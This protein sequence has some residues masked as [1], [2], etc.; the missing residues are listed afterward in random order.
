MKGL[1]GHILS[2][3]TNHFDLPAA[4]IA[5]LYKQRW[6]VELLFKWIKHHLRIKS[7]FGTTANAVR[8]QLWIA[9]T[10]YVLVAILKK[11]LQLK[12]S[13]YTILQVLSL[14]LFEKTPI[15][16][17]LSQSKL[18]LDLEDDCE[19]LIPFDF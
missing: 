1:L 9:I 7:F 14:T 5:A 2:F 4:T 17:I 18:S 12:A 8:T 6:Q 19:Q 3:L 11:E 15:Q 13:L 10:V 16:E